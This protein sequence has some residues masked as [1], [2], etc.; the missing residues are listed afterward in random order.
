M[1]LVVDWKLSISPVLGILANLQSF[2][3]FVFLPVS[4]VLCVRVAL[5]ENPYQ[6]CKI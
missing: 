5:L 1:F 3:V 6:K 4:L 2:Q